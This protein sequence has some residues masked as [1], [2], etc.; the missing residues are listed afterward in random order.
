MSLIAES[1]RFAKNRYFG[2]NDDG[3]PKTVPS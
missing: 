3:T 1:R 2:V